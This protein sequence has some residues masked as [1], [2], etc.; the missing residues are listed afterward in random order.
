MNETITSV[1]SRDAREM[2]ASEGVELY[3]DLTYE[4]GRE[5]SLALSE[6]AVND[7]IAEIEGLDRD[8]Q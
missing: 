5:V 6:A 7:L 2:I 8:D 1:D 4:A 3:L